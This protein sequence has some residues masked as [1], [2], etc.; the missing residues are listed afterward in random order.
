MEI[1]AIL[2]IAGIVGLGIYSYRSTT[3]NEPV[4][5][6]PTVNKLSKARLTALTKAQLVEKGNEL[7][8]KVNTREVKSKIVNQV[9]KAQ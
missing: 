9:Y 5:E 8:V 4:V 6:T 7:G 3:D 1:I 2:L